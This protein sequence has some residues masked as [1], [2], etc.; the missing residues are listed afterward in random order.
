[1]VTDVSKFLK[2]TI[3]A[4]K[5]AFPQS[6]EASSHG[7]VKYVEDSHHRQYSIY[8]KPARFDWQKE[9]RVVLYSPRS[10]GNALILQV[11]GLRGVWQFIGNLE[12]SATIVQDQFGELGLAFSSKEK[13]A[14][15]P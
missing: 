1:M 14:T 13:A 5:R 10:S 15:A 7:P 2:L 3:A 8:C 11:P 6:I 4:I 9:F 12:P